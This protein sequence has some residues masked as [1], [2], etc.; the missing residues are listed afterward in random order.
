M[1]EQ[2]SDGS[3]RARVLRQ[4]PPAHSQQQR[5]EDH[6]LPSEIHSR[7]RALSQQIQ[8]LRSQQ[9]QRLLRGTRSTSGRRIV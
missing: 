7:R 2:R 1:R 6:R 9:E 3:R 5:G 8:I 4:E